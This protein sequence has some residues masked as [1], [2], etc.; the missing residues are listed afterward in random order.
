MLNIS[1]LQFDI[2][3]TKILNGIDLSIQRGEQ[4]GIIG[5]N[6]C[7]K[8][9][10][11]NCICGFYR[12]TGGSIEFKNEDI[13]HFPP[14]R[15]AN[16][17]IGRVFQ[18][19]GIFREMTLLENILTALESKKK[20]S[21]LPWSSKNRALQAETFQYLEMVGL[22]G[23]AND[24]AGS[25]SGGQMRLLE[26]TRAIAFGSELLLL[27]EPTAGVSPKMKT[28]ILHVLQKLHELGKT[29]LII[30]HDINFIQQLCNRVIV[31]DVGKVVLDGAPEQV[32]SDTRLQEVYFGTINDKDEG[33]GKIPLTI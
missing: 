31:L 8:T 24:K 7:G 3:Q 29:V 12:P 17:G 32:R 28:E 15:R 14:H 21:I 11:F 16:L 9:T 26:I 5:P 2:G 19:F 27:D 23:K 18:N 10:L 20:S 1:H 22:Q 30:E 13:S 33:L 6:G 4:T 25:L